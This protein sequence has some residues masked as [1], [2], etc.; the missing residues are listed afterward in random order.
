M[1]YE[2]SC[3]DD[4]AFA[5]VCMIEHGGSHA[6][7]GAVVNGAAMEGDVMSDGDVVAYLECCFL[8][9]GMETAAVLYVDSVA[10]ADVVDIASHNGIEPYGTLVAHGDIAYDSGVF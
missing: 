8:I 1:E 3:G 5:D 4:G 7:E 2:G 10:D 9:E 6:D